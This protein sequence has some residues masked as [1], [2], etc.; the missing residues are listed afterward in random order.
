MGHGYGYGMGP[1]MM[2]GGGYGYGM[3]PGMMGG[4]GY[5]YGMGPGMRGGLGY[6]G[7]GMR[8]GRGYGHWRQNTRTIDAKEAENMIKD[9]LQ[10]TGNPNLMLGK[11]KEEQGA[12][13]A[14][15][16]TKNND[17]VDTVRI[18]KKTGFIQ[19]IYQQ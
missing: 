17:L 3:G 18:D 15:I 14:D 11:I 19:S 7:Y 2:Y 4:G 1:G 13:E 16:V 10:F 12:F 5:G 9:Y 6:Y 8:G